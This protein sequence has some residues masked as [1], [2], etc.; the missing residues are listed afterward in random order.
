MRFSLAIFAIAATYASA[1][2]LSAETKTTEAGWGIFT[3]SFDSF[4]EK[5]FK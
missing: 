3:N 4:T 5:A 2:G 1:S